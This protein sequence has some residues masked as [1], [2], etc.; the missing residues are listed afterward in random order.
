MNKEHERTA[1]DP[2][3]SKNCEQIGVAL[4]EHNIEVDNV[5]VRVVG[6][7]KSSGSK[8]DS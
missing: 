6:E 7:I 2:P 3:E 4:L 5:D 1:S 8:E